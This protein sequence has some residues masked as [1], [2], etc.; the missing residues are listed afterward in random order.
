MGSN[1]SSAPL[2]AAMVVNF[3]TVLLMVGIGTFHLSKEVQA[4]MFI[5]V[6]VGVITSLALLFLGYM[7]YRRRPKPSPANR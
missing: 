5:G 6:F 7:I 1:N 2:Y 4:W 3:I